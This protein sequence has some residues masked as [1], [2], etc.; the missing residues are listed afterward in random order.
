[1]EGGREGGG[2]GAVRGAEG[3]WRVEEV[4]CCYYD[5]TEGCLF[6]GG[7]KCLSESMKTKRLQIFLLFN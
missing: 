1:M 5:A 3:W 7:G 6:W 4:F 2:R